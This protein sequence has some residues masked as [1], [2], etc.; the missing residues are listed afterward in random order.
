MEAYCEHNIFAVAGA[1]NRAT[2]AC[3]NKRKNSN[4]SGRG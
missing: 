2:F 1:L 4:F 3:F